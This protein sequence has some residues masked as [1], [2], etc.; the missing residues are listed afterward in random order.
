MG[1]SSVAEEGPEVRRRRR[2]QIWE[3]RRTEALMVSAVGSLV[4]WLRAARPSARQP[5]SL[6]PFIR[7]FYFLLS[8]QL[9]PRGHPQCVRSFAH[10]S[11]RRLLVVSIRR[12]L[13]SEVALPHIRPR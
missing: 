8:H 13:P 12:R 5:A 9:Q 10:Q 7:S 4:G 2:E 3:E 6:P 11:A 1:H